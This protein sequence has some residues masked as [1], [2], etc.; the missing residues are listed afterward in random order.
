[1]P[2]HHGRRLEHADLSDADPPTEEASEAAVIKTVPDHGSGPVG[3]HRELVPQAGQRPQR[4]DGVG[5]R[6]QVAA[7]ARP[8][9]R[10]VTQRKSS[11]WL[12]A[13]SRKEYSSCFS[14]QR[15]AASRPSE[16][17]RS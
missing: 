7:R 17:L 4:R 12:I 11:Y 6:R 10:D 13:V 9:A 8:S 2:V 15:L 1:V 5:E 3:Q 14:R 16:L